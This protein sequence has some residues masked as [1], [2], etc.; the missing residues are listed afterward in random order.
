[1]LLS[2]SIFFIFYTTLYKMTTLNNRINLVDALRGFALLGIVLLHHVEHFDIANFVESSYPL[3]TA[4]DK[5]LWNTVFFIFGG[6]MYAIFALTFGF[7]FYIQLENHKRRGE[8]FAGR[9]FWRMCLLFMFGFLHVM[10]YSGEILSVYALAG[11]LIIPLRNL[12]TKT[13]TVLMIIFMLEPWELVQ[14]GI[15]LF[16]NEYIPSSY[17]RI[18]YFNAV[19]AATTGTFWDMVTTNLTSGMVNSHIFAWRSGRYFQ[20]LSLFLLGIITG[21][22]GLFAEAE[23]RNRCWKK[24]WCISIIC[25]IPL[26]IL[27]VC[28]AIAELRPGISTPLSVMLS[29]WSN[30]S[31]AT[32]LVSSFV[33]L[34]VKTKRWNIEF[35]RLIP[36]GRMSLSNYICSSIFG[37]FIYYHWGLGL[38]TTSGALVSLLTGM[39]IFTIQLFFSKWWLTHHRRGPLEWVWNKLMWIKLK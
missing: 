2:F 11:M 31:F 6:K 19:E 18:F 8:N 27:K 36:Y 37:S 16:N 17:P 21:R 38:N 23:K 25:F 20:T 39:A 1:M 26:Y 29:M 10:F 9:F 24:V 35:G 7:S 4:I 34:W 12:N 22:G 3:L 15:G 13:L 28:P 32:F 33:L 14:L 5:F 30:L